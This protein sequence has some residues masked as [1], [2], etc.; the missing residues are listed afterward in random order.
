[1]SKRIIKSLIVASLF[2]NFAWAGNH[3]KYVNPFIGT[4]AVENSLSG[5]CYPGATLPFGMVQLSPD[6]QDAPD[7]DKASGY[8]YNDQNIMGFSHT[9]LYS[10]TS[11][12]MQ[13]EAIL[14]PT[15]AHSTWQKA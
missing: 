12:A 15:I 7:W 8:D 9:R 3:T 1:M 6:T 5:N 4:G 13:T 11:I 10:Q 2:G 14:H